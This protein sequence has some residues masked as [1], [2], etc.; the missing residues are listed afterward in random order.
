[1]RKENWLIIWPNFEIYFIP[2]S[3]SRSL[4]LKYTSRCSKICS[5]CVGRF[6]IK[7]LLINKTVPIPTMEVNVGYFLLVITWNN[8]EKIT[9]F[10]VIN[11]WILCYLGLVLYWGRSLTFYLLLLGN[12]SS[13]FSEEI[14]IRDVDRLSGCI[15]SIYAYS[16]QF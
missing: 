6:V 12:V 1:M 8:Q 15:I 16:D 14:N 5:L 11:S 9:Y 4:T 7:L 2:V 13:Q 3:A 10:H